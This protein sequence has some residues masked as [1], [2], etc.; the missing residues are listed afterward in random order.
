MCERKDSCS[1]LNPKQGSVRGEVRVAEMI[2]G[3]GSADRGNEGQRRKGKR[4]AARK[5]ETKGSV[6]RGNEAQKKSIY[7]LHFCKEQT[8]ECKASADE[9]PR[10]T[11]GFPVFFCATAPGAFTL[12]FPGFGPGFPFGPVDFPSPFPAT[13]ASLFLTPS[14]PLRFFTPSSS[15]SSFPTFPFT[16]AFPP[17]FPF[18]FFSSSTTYPS[19]SF[20]MRARFSPPLHSE[21]HHSKAL[22]ARLSTVL[23]ADTNHNKAL[24]CAKACVVPRPVLGKDLCCAKTCVVLRPV[25]GCVGV[26]SPK[27]ILA[28]HLVKVHSLH[29]QR[30]EPSWPRT[31]SPRCSLQ[32]LDFCREAAD[33]RPRPNP[34]PPYLRPHTGSA[35]R[36]HH[37]RW[38]SAQ[39]GLHTEHM[40]HRM[41][42]G[43]RQCTHSRSKRTKIHSEQQ[44]NREDSTSC[45]GGRPCSNS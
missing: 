42:Y 27:Q 16:L 31:I 44:N 14:P 32:P 40:V 22:C 30:P 37:S 19:D 6:K 36:A 38:Y 8:G 41:T 43:S 15:S 21:T 35:V 24:C 1:F 23:Q 18:L 25:L 33:P 17:P 34:A 45:T 13:P 20:M 12:A 29:G 11:P 2:A 26:H 4:R 3:K 9:A 7:L 10:L 28:Q 39:G 5:G